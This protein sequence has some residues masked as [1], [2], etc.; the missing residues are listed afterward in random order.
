MRLNLSSLRAG[1]ATRLYLSGV[2]V[3]RI[4]YRGR[5]LHERTVAVYIQEAVAS[6]CFTVVSPPV[7]RSFQC[8]LAKAQQF[9]E[10]P[11]QPWAALSAL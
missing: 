5:W 8:L 2:E 7:L 9:W 3:R 6:L 10:P 1:G 11:P 4:Q